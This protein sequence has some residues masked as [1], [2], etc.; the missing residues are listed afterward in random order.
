MAV[1]RDGTPLERLPGIGPRL[2]ERLGRLGITRVEDLPFHLP[3]RYEDRSR[4]VR[5]GELRPGESVLAEGEITAAEVVAGRRRRLVCRLADGS[6]SLELV[7]FHFFGAHRQRLTRGARVRVFGEVR[8]G[9]V[10][11][12]MVHPEWEVVA[13]DAPPPAGGLTPCYPATEGVTQQQL[14]RAVTGALE[15]AEAVRDWLPSALVQRQQLPDLATALATVHAPPIEADT[16]AL[17]EGR[18]PAVRRLAFEELLAHRLSLLRLRRAH[19][20]ARPAP[21][22]AG[23]EDRHAALLQRLGFALTDAQS[24]VRREIAADLASEQPTLRLV[25]GDVG[26][27]KT[28]VAALAALTAVASGHQ[29]AVMAPTELLAEQHFRNFRDWLEP[30]GV[31]VAWVSG[32]LSAAR[33]RETLAALAEGEAQVVIGTHALFQEG[34]R[35]ARLGL[36]VV[37]EQHRFGVHQ[38]LALRDKG[39]DGRTQ[40]HQLVMTATP[41]PRTLAMTAYADLDVSVID[42][43]P[44]GRQPVT[45]VAIPDSRRAEVVERVR[46]ACAEGRQAYWVCTLVESSELLE[47]EAAEATAERLRES[48]PELR[49]GLVHGR[50]KAS[51][52][53]AVMAAFEAGELDLLVATTVIEVG[54][55]VPNAS[56]MIIEN[57]ERLGLAQLHQLRG[58]VGRGDAQS[59]CVLLYHGPLTETARARLGVLRESNDGFRIAR[60]DLELRGP[61]ELLGTRQTGALEYR[62]ADLHRDADL[63][64]AVQAEADALLD[65]YP[66]AAAALIRRWVGEGERYAQV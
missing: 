64:D 49:V 63:I 37:D 1:A 28:V 52:K 55:N 30:L 4:C 65:D 58:R 39:D 2:G 56:L 51:D 16:R 46:A 19:Q 41:I 5:L 61:G 60:R 9:P 43:L 24:R 17:L 53:E 40:P 12:Q 44:P 3:L 15:S 54:V 13:A 36:V 29:A 48:L 7:F 38:R 26:S 50:V 62:I 14:R 42:E 34:V 23:G 25:Q 47:A 27:G 8:P 11:L 57:P 33:R 59:S 21:V 22:L 18:H 6:G 45:T 31:R 10:M 35:F 32:R 66:E 20:A